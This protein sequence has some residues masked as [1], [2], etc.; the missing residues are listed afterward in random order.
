[1]DSF[2]TKQRKAAGNLT[3][4]FLCM[5]GTYIFLISGFANGADWRHQLQRTLMQSAERMYLPRAS[6]ILH[7]PD[8]TVGEWLADQAMSLIPIVRYIDEQKK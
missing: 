7:T 2:R 8:R 4:V 6:Y 5:I 3:A 1:M